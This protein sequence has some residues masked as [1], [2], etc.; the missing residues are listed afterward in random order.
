M[1]S[2]G[3]AACV[4]CPILFALC[5]TLWRDLDRVK[6]ELEEVRDRYEVRGFPR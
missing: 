2:L 6:R 4:A 3:L 1:V 5:V